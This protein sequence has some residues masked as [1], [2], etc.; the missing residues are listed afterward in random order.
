MAKKD[1]SNV[2]TSTKEKESAISKSRFPPP[3]RPMKRHE[4]LELDLKSGDDESKIADLRREAI[5]K[6]RKMPTSE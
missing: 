3:D 6:A 4:N 5:E 2:K 1:E